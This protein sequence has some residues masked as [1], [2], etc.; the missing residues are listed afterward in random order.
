M[1]NRYQTTFTEEPED[2]S[3]GTVAGNFDNARVTSH[4]SESE[5]IGFGLAVSRG[6]I[7]DAGVL[8]GADSLEQFLGCSMKDNTLPARNGDRFLIG[9]AL[10]V[11]ESG[12]IWVAPGVAVAKGDPVYF[13]PFTGVLSNT[14]GIGPILGAKWKTGSVLGRA[15]VSLPSYGQ[16]AALA[17]AANYDPITG[18]GS[19]LIEMWDAA[20]ADSLTVTDPNLVSAWLGLVLGSNLAQ[21]TTNLKPVYQPEGFNGA[22]CLSFDGTQQYLTCT[23]AP[24]MA[25]LPDGAETGELWVVVDQAA[26]PADT[27]ERYAAGWCGSSVVTGRAISR[28]VTTGVNRT[29]GRTGIGASSTNADGTTVDFSGRHVVRHI[30]GATQ[31]SL[32]VDGGANVTVSAVPSTTNTR[33]RA[34]SIPAAG[35][36]NYWNG[37]IAAIVA[38]KTL[39]TDKATALHNYLG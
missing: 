38:T 39:D 18:L 33:F 19:D 22:P 27:G 29:R 3:P 35:P 1:A 34:G 2:N 8:L 6:Y 28:I 17:V 25:A 31:S 36:G 20:R 32:S 23:D 24:L 26:L 9:N 10:S 4:T 7:T 11:L 13:D 5:A 37:K 16:G 12:D 21:T 15:L 30:V 14:G